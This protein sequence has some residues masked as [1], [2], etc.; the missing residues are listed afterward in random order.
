MREARWACLWGCVG[1]LWLL[2]ACD[3]GTSEAGA[4]PTA[5]TDSPAVAPNAA[6]RSGEWKAKSEAGDD[7]VRIEID[8]EVARIRFGDKSIASEVRN[9]T[10]KYT[11]DGAWVAAVKPGGDTFKLLGEDGKLLWKVKMTPDK[12]KVSDNEENEGGYE[13]KPREDGGFKMKRHDNEVGKLNFYPE[14]KRIKVKDK[15]GNAVFK[16]GE[17]SEGSP[18][19]LVLLATDIP[20]PLRYVVMAEM[21]ARGR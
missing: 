19:W 4:A 10:R 8:G 13:I 20:E 6:A 12:I 15:D 18:K 14:D 21:A 17:Q 16:A 11:L 5:A 7:V 3:R 1:L 9:G 2:A